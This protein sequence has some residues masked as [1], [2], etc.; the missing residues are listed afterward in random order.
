M[1]NY[2]SE[3]LPALTVHNAQVG[4]LV[5]TGNPNL[6]PTKETGMKYFRKYKIGLNF[7]SPLLVKVVWGRVKVV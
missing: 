2:F 3:Q 4:S 6:F 5:N 1:S 7:A